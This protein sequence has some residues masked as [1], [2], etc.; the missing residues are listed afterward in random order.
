M[1]SR[2]C[3]FGLWLSIMMMSG[4]SQADSGKTKWEDADLSYDQARRALSRGEIL[5]IERLLE[6]VKAQLPGQV[7]ELEF[8]REDGR[9]VYEM[10]IIDADGRLL[11][12]YFDAKSGD[13]ISVDGRQSE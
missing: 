1:L 9:W 5:P 10:K 6:R 8:E 4:L 13:L 7:L 2:A 11:D 3:T 12:A